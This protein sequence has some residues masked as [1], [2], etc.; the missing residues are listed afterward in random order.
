LLTEYLAP[1]LVDI[2]QPEVELV[3]LTGGRRLSYACWLHRVRLVPHNWSTAIRTAAIL[4]WL[5]ALPPLT[6]GIYQQEA[7]FELD[8]TEHPFRDAVVR[9][10]PV[11]GEDGCI[12]VPAGPG[13]GIEV[14]AEAVERWRTELITVT[15]EGV[16]TL[17]SGA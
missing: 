9:K 17:P 16:R 11:L 3:G 5:A 6:E 8:S 4:H 15:R 12:A 10:A 13:L 7:M 1:K 14:V 2:V